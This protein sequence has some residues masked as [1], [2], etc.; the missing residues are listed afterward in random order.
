[1]F[2]RCYPDRI[3]TRRIEAEDRMSVLQ[4]LRDKTL[5]DA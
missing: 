2:L 4:D 5:A 1:M 3:T